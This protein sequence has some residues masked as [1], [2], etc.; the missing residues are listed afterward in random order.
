MLTLT[1]ISDIEKG[2]YFN[3]KKLVG[4]GMSG[5]VY[6]INVGYVVKKLRSD[7]DKPIYNKSFRLELETTIILS[8]SKISPKV[9]Y[10]SGGRSSFNYFVMERM[11]YTLY[12]MLKNNIFTNKHLVKLQNILERLNKTD[13][14]HAD[15]H[16]NNIMWSNKLDDFRI[17]DWGSYNK[18]KDKQNNKQ[19]PK[20][21]KKI[22]NWMNH[23]YRICRCFGVKI[24]KIRL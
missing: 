6:S 20:L 16:L 22:D 21:V 9:S 18:T 12:Y 13:Y 5:A 11:D 17:I 1:E 4:R 3:N 19:S 8:C 7:R 24:C 10:H 15:L 23:S 14:R 2:V